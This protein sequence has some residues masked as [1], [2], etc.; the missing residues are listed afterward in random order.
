MQL[1]SDLLG[2]VCEQKTLSSFRG[3]AFQPMNR[4][5]EAGVSERTVLVYM[6]FI[7]CARV[8]PIIKREFSVYLINKPGFADYK[9]TFQRLQNASSHQYLCSTALRF[10][11]AC[12]DGSL[13]GFFER[14]EKKALLILQMP[15]GL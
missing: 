14:I 15:P 7:Q 6:A 10:Q 11:I 9:K 12:R 1:V 13:V 2:L 3:S 8:T 4:S 5:I